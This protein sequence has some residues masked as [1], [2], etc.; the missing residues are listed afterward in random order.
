ML[1]LTKL[2][3]LE[4]ALEGVDVGVSAGVAADEGVVAGIAV[5]R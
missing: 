2:L 5:I 3:L 1:S 4:V